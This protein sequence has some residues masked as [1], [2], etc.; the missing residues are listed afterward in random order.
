[1]TEKDFAFNLDKDTYNFM[2]SMF[3]SYDSCN[4]GH[5]LLFKGHDNPKECF[6]IKFMEHQNDINRVYVRKMKC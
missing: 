4:S 3:V 1:M 5:G 2:K 6:Q